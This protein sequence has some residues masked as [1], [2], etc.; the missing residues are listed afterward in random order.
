MKLTKLLSGKKI[1]KDIHFWV[2]TSSYVADLARRMRLIGII[3]KCGAKITTTCAVISPITRWGFKTV[4]TN[5][6]KFANVIPSEHQLGIQY[7]SLE[8]CIEVAA[9]G[10]RQ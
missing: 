6:A 10:G 5:S 9:S 4:L 1:R 3:E 2:Y 8:R 7:A